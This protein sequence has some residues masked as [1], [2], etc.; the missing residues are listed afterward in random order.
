[1]SQILQ[2]EN[3]IA[4]I[5]AKQRSILERLGGV[6]DPEAHRAL[7]KQFRDL[8]IELRGLLLK[9]DKFRRPEM[10]RWP[11]SAASS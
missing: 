2:W 7:T 6:S 8:Q 9:R 4:V 11:T 5:E 1:M 10:Y 3:R